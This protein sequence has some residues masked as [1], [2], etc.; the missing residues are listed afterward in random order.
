MKF[1]QLNFLKELF[2]EENVEEQKYSDE[3]E[4]EE[5]QLVLSEID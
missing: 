4:L 1:E 2:S 3:L 5:L